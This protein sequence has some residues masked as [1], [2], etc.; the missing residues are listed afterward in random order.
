[1]HVKKSVVICEARI[2]LYPYTNIAKVGKERRTPSLSFSSMGNWPGREERRRK[3][4][5]TTGGKKKTGC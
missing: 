2:L 1:M 4:A 5:I 3:D